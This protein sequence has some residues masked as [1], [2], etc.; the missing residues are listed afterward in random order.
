MDQANTLIKQIHDLNKRIARL[1]GGGGNTNDYKDQLDVLIDE[2]SLLMDIQVKSNPNGTST[3]VM[4]GRTIASDKMYTLPEAREDSVTKMNEIY[5]TGSDDPCL[6]SGQN[7]ELKVLL[8]FRDQK[9]PEHINFLDDLARGM[10]EN[11]NLIHR[12]GYTL[13]EPPSPGGD[14]FEKNDFSADYSAANFRLSQDILNDYSRIAASSTGAPGDGENAITLSRVRE[15]SLGAW[16]MA[17][18]P[19][20]DGG[21]SFTLSVNEVDVEITLNEQFETTDALVKFINSEISESDLAGRV[22][23]YTDGVGSFSPHLPVSW[24]SLMM[25]RERR[26]KTGE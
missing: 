16:S 20:H 11:I 19:E 24:L 21:E 6:L 23:A 8:D 3:L 26:Y 5:I 17:N 2:L 18:F 4:Q 12:D 7:G 14:F 1:G 13:E 9:I 10:V 22:S 25:K 15:R